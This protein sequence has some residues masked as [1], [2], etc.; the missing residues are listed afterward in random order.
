MS[1]GG[2][3][4]NA[5]GYH[6]CPD[7]MAVLDMQNIRKT[8]QQN[9]AV[10]LQL[11]AENEPNPSPQTLSVV[12]VGQGSISSLP[13]GIDCGVT[14]SHAFD[15]DTP[16]TLTAAADTDWTF[17]SW[18]GACTGLGTCQVTMDAA[19]SVTA[20][21][22]PRP[23][24]VLVENLQPSWTATGGGGVLAAY[25]GPPDYDAVS[26][27]TTTLYDGREAAIIKAGLALDPDG[28]YWDEGILAF[29][30]NNVDL[31]SFASQ[32]LLFDVE[33]ATG[34]NPVWVRIRLT[35]TNQTT[36]QFVPTT[37]PAGWHTVDAAAGM[38]QLMD[39]NGNATGPMMSLAE[40]ATAN[41]GLAVDRVYLTL[42]M[43]DSYNVS[44]GVGTVAW[45]DKVTIDRVTY[46]FVA[47]TVVL[48]ARLVSDWD[49]GVFS[50]YVAPP[51]YYYVSP[52]TTAVYDGREAGI[53][54][55]GLTP[56]P[57]GHY[58]DEGLFG[59]RPTY[60][61]NAFAAGTVTYDVETQYGEN[62]VW[63]T[64]EIDTGVVGDRA[65]NTTYQFVPV[66]NPA[67]WHTVDAAAGLWQKWNNNDGDVT[68]NPLI[69]LSDVAAAHSGLNVVR[70]YLRLGM[71]DSY[72]GSGGLGTI[73]WVDKAT[74]GGVTY[75]FVVN[76]LSVVKVGSGTVTSAPVGINCGETCSYAFDYDTPV[77]LTAA[78]DTGWTFTGWSGACTGTGTCQVTM[79]AAKS[80]TA[81]FRE[82]AAVL[83]SPSGPLTTWDHTFRWTGISPATWY[84]LEV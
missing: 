14:C 46:D 53:I 5:P 45:V 27:G 21:F 22:L 72:H 2:T 23:I 73:A 4:Y 48:V 30:V 78:A 8:A 52:G 11:D 61:I 84:L 43:G 80:V 41:P 63:M 55:A 31:T 36:Y 16:V 50:A 35:D 6:N 66:T 1:I 32:A 82:T 13:A 17:S 59:F 12:N 44:P 83:S 37:N 33:N 49:T 79:D 25:Y 77:T 15:Y 65:D 28:H 62:P 56:K 26:P 70:A 20:R 38:W 57:D 19:K 18:D 47:P 74:L 3:P 60:T 67:G 71:G 42:G 64:I 40:V 68:G 75:D 7:V 81:N 9:L 58:D 39:E 29:R 54:K 10:L 34:P 69:S 76:T 51:D 24:T